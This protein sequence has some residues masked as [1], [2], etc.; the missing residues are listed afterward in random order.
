MAKRLNDYMTRVLSGNNPR[1]RVNLKEL[2]GGFVPDSGQFR[3]AVGQEIIDR[4][5]ERTKSN[6]SW[7]GK[8]F[9]NYSKAYAESIEFVAA[10]KSKSDPNL[11]QSG[12]MLALLDIVDE[13]EDWIEIGWS[14]ADEAAKAH[15]HI[16]GNIGVTRDFLGLPGRDLEEISDE[17]RDMLPDDD[18]LSGIGESLTERAGAFVAGER[19][20]QAG[21]TF[22]ELLSQLLEFEE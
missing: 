12:D 1:L 8:R 18:I 16:T 7:D 19:S 10:G 22:E 11:T 17:F 20:I 15:G 3:A 5:R 14:D 2:F 9:R 6:L 21:L 4:I 13:G